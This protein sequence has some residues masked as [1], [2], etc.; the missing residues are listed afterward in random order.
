MI[1]GY[2]RLARS[3]TEYSFSSLLG[4]QEMLPMASGYKNK[5][6]N[7]VTIQVGAPPWWPVHSLF[8]RCMRE[9]QEDGCP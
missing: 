7:V 9:T 6:S 2:A 3:L 8:G 4:R 1:H 5:V